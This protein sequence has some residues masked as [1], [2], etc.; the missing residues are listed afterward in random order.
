M[1]K[2]PL[3]LLAMNKIDYFKKDGLLKFS[4]DPHSPHTIIPSL[5]PEKSTILDIGCNTGFF[6]KQML[7][8]KCITDG[9]DV[10]EEALR[11][12]KKYCRNT[13]QRNLYNPVLELSRRSYDYI[14]MSDILE[15]LPRPDLLL[16]DVSQYLSKSGFV[17]ASIPNIARFELRLKHL[18]GKFDYAP[19]IMSF[20]HLRFFTQQTIRQLFIQ[21]GY[22]IIRVIP[23]G[24]GHR[25]P[26]L[27]NLLA[28]QFIIIAKQHSR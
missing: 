20:D 4:T 14:V 9:V 24:L 16:Q 25:F 27:P 13:F 8:K 12:A 22:D 3:S 28:F 2:L 21:S 15:H 1:S 10:N 6:A 19:G 11:I 23:T 17:I 26:I 18:F 5:I 7:D